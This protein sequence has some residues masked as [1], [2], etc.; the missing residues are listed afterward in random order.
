V[1]E[2]PPV[3]GGPVIAWLT[4]IGTVV[5][6]VL[7]ARSDEPLLVKLLFVGLTALG[8]CLIVVFYL[9]SW[10]ERLRLMRQIKALERERDRRLVDPPG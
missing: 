1:T 6:L 8:I 9:G 4:I 5:A 2:R 3:P 10:R 7:L